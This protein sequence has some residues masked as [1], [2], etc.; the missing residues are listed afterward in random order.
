VISRNAL[1]KGHIAD[2]GSQLSGVVARVEVEEGD[3]VEAGRILATFEDRQLRANV[4]KARSKLRK[5]TRGL[6]AERLEIEHERL[7]LASQVSEATAQLGAA[8]AQLEAAQSRADDAKERLSLRQSL[9]DQGIIPQEELRLAESEH[10]T[11][12]ALVSAMLAEREAAQAARHS[13]KVD[14]AGLAV[15]ERR[16]AVLE[17]DVDALAAELAVAEADL[18]ASVIRAPDD[19]WV[20]RR[21]VEPGASVVAG[22]PLVSLWTGDQVWVEA[23]IDE[24]DL[25]HVGVGSEANVTLKPYPDREFTGVVDRIGVSTDYELPEEDVPTPR[26]ARMRGTPIVSVR[27]RLQEQEGLFPGMSAIVGIRKTKRDPGSL[28]RGR[29]GEAPILRTR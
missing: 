15:R 4:D 2:V 9:A 13:A 28:G 29:P 22:Q 21:I 20:V 19:G 24:D 18:Q 27:V 26:H 3:R 6:E 11:A 5:A 12:L 10:R 17:A 8:R 16:L 25:G 14:S 7:R 23:W 1:V